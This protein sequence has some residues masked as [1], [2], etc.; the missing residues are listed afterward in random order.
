MTPE[1]KPG[2]PGL[3]SMMMIF[4]TTSHV[5]IAHA[6]RVIFNKR[7]TGLNFVTHQGGENLVG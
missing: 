3:F 2:E 6:Q 4:I 7:T 1:K 5:K